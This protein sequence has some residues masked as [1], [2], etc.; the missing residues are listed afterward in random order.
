MGEHS[1]GGG[2]RL[3]RRGLLLGGA[4]GTLGVGVVAGWD[5]LS[6]LWWRHSGV[7]EIPREEGEVDLGTAEWIPASP[8]NYRRANRPRDYTID[9]VVI[10]MPEA[11]YPITL[12][13]FQDPGHGSST[14][15]V[16]RS[17]DGHVAQLVRE[18]D[19]AYHAGNRSFNERSIGIEHEGW[20]DEP[21]YLTDAM[22]ESSARLV[23]D[24][25]RR[26]EIPVDREHIL[27]H[28]EV[29]DVI[30]TCPGPH[31]DWDRYMGLVR[32]E[33]ERPGPARSGD[34]AQT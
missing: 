12:R 8:A 20:A 33:A 7:A 16:L 25:C 13:V 3:G 9:R 19:V 14:H 23:A 28:N 26:Y 2:G 34:P 32:R 29:P 11:T 5:S 10:H 17:S 15:Y 31:W 6:R 27:G 24:I 22:Y 1:A 30:R 4:A 21:S 18:L